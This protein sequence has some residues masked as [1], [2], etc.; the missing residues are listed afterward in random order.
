MKLSRCF[1]V[2]ALMLLLSTAAHPLAAD[3]E[4]SFG[5]RHNP[6]QRPEASADSTPAQVTERAEREEIKEVPP[7]FVLKATLVSEARPLVGVE[8]EIIGVGDLFQG[9]R[10]V[11][12]NE[13]QAVFSKGSKHYTL[14]VG[15]ESRN[16]VDD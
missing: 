7:D 13:G 11:S 12:V 6:F 3:E 14:K 2:V 9:Y 16:A 5:L 8:G 1:V 10:L 4:M 15:A